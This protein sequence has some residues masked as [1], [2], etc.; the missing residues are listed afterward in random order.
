MQNDPK[1]LR[2]LLPSAYFK[3]K[4]SGEGKRGN[5]FAEWHVA[6]FAE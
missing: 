4:R 2:G 3:E 6:W 1:K 5:E